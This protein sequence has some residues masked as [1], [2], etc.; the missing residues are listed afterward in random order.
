MAAGVRAETVVGGPDLTRQLLDAG[1]VDQLHVDVV[2]V[3]LGAGLGCSRGRARSP[4]RSWASRGSAC[5]PA[6]VS[7][8]RHPR[9]DR[10]T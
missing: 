8:W 9:A 6:C 1:L 4:W 10:C 5:A 7:R 2:P 3:L